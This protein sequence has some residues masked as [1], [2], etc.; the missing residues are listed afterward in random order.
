M[1]SRPKPATAAW[2]QRERHRL[3]LKPADLA[4]RLKAQGVEVGEQTIRVWESNVDRRPSAYNLE[5]LERIFGSTAPERGAAGDSAA[6]VAAIDRLTVAVERQTEERVAWER[7]LVAAI[8]ELVRSARSSGGLSY[9][10]RAQAR[11]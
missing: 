3:G 10:P 5:A 2:I 11:G 9:E 7:E 1:S 8:G 6:I 4:A